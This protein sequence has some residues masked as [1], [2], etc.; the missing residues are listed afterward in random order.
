[1]QPVHSVIPEEGDETMR[2]AFTPVLLR[3]L[4]LLFVMLFDTHSDAAD[5][6][7]RK[8]VLIAGKKSHGPVGNGIHDYPWS[9]KLLKVMVDNSNVKD[10][11]RVEY[12]LEGWPEDERTFDDADTIMVISDG[13]DG[14]LYEEAPQFSTP[15]H[16]ACV[17]RQ[18]QRGCGFVTFHFSTFAPDKYADQILAWSGGYFD[19]ETDGKRQWYSAINTRDTE[20]LPASPEHPVLRGVKPFKMNEE[21]YYNLRFRPD[22]KA[23]KPIWVVPA[24]PGREP[25][26]RIVAWARERDDGGRGFGTT[27]GHFYANWQHDNF[28]R[29]ILNALA[30][31]AKVEVPP[32]GVAARF[33]THAEITAALA[34]VTGVE[35]AVVDDRP[36]KVLVLTG[37]QY[38]GH[39][40]AE[41]TPA[42]KESLARDA[43]F[44]VDVSEE[45]EVLATPKIFDYAAL[46]LNYCN[47]MKPGLSDASKA[48]FVKYLEQGGGL[49]IIHFANGAFHFSLPEAKES[50]WP[51]FRKICRRAWDHTPGKSGHDAYG[52]FIVEIAP[53]EHPVTAGMSAFQTI[54]ELYFR[55][56]GEE[57]I[58]VLATAKSQVTGQNEPM[59]FVYNYGKG[60]VFQTVLGHAAESLR[61]PGAAELVRRGTTWVAGRSIAALPPLEAASAPVVP[62][63]PASTK[64][65]VEGRF[66]QALNARA[67]GAF[68]PAKAAYRTPPLTVECWA[69]LDS[70]QSYNILVA[71]ELKTSATH[72]EL[73]SMT[74]SGQFTAYLPGMRPDH[75][76]SQV[77]ICDGKWH[78]LAM[79]F[80]PT[81][82]RL[83]VDGKQVA[84][85]GVQ[86]QNGK[87]IEGACAFGALVAKEIGC[88]GAIDEVRI[89]SG[90]RDI[91]GVPESPFEPDEQTRGLWHFDALDAGNRIPDAARE[92]SPAQLGSPLEPAGKPA[93]QKQ[94]QN[95]DHFGEDA[96]GF[97]WTEQDAVDNRWNQTDLGICMASTLFFPGDVV[98]KGLSIR[99]GEQGEATMCFDTGTLAYR[100]GWTGGFLDFNPARFGLISSPKIAGRLQFASRDHPGYAVSGSKS[101]G[102][103]RGH[104]LHDDRIVLVYDIGD[105]SVRETPWFER[106]DEESA[107][108]RTLEIGPHQNPFVLPILNID[109]TNF[110]TIQHG[111]P[112]AG[113]TRA[114]QATAVAVL[115]LSDL[116]PTVAGKSQIVVT[117]P[118]SRETQRFKLLIWCGWD[119]QL[120][121]FATLVQSSPVPESV[122]FLQQPGGP[123][124][125]KPIETQGTLGVSDA[126]YTLDTL[127]LPFD[128]PYKA[129]LFVSGHDFF[130]NGDI[131]ACTVHGDVWRISGADERLEKLTWKRFATGL[132][133]PLGLKV[134]NDQVYVLG[135]DQITRL[136]D[137]NG[138][139]EADEY[140]NFNNAYRTSPGGHDYVACLETD[141]AGNLYFVHANQGL[142]KVSPD[143]A[144]LDVVAT[145]F[146][147]PN[148]LG[149]GADGTI[150]VSPQEGNWTPASS[151]VQVKP[152][153]YYGFGG[154][155]VSDERPL[156]YDPPLCWIPRLRDNSSGG[157][158]WVTSDR[159]G[160]LAGQLLHFS[161]GKCRMLLTLREQVEGVM[162]GG[163]IDFPLN[164]DSGVM[165]GR[166]H[167]R[168]GQL[169]V[170]GLKGWVSSAVQDGCLQRVRYTGKPVDLPVAVRTRQNGLELEFTRP[171][172][173]RS[174]EDPDSYHVQR[175]N[176]LYTGNYGSAEYKVSK[177]SEEG[178]DEVDVLSATL[179][180]DRTVFLELDD[181]RPVMQMAIEYDLQTADGTALRDT[182]SYTV[183]A[184]GSARVDPA[185]LTRRPHPGQ[186]TAEQ[187]AA[188]QPGLR[189]T[190]QQDGR[191]DNR[192]ARLAALSVPAGAYPS[193]FLKPGP[194]SAVFT[195]YLERH[196]K[197]RVSIR[198][199]GHGEAELRINGSDV[200]RGSGDLAQT[201]AADVRLHKGFNRIELRYSS[202]VDGKAT[203]RLLWESPE[204][205]L[206]PIPST[207]LMTDGAAPELLAASRL[208]RGRELFATL[209]CVKC[210]A[211]PA[212]V[213]SSREAMPEL[214]R[215][216]PRLGDAG[217]VFHPEWVARWLL[218]PPSLRSP[219]TMP[220]LFNG[221][222]EADRQQAADLAAY[223]A[224]LAPAAASGSAPDEAT[225]SERVARG[226]ILYEDLGCI[227]CHRLTPPGESDPFSRTSLHFVAA[228]YRPAALAAFLRQPHRRYEFTR[229][230]DFQLNPT[231]AESLARYLESA[232]SMNRL[233]EVAIPVGSS[234][235]GQALF[236]T[237]RCANCHALDR[238]APGAAVV[239]AVPLPAQVAE[240]GCLS[241]GAV[242]GIP[243]FSLDAADRA[244]LAEF[245]ATDRRSLEQD[246]TS[247]ISE[248]LA[249]TLNCTACHT[250]DRQ[251]APRGSLLV[252]EG[253]RGL[254]P[255]VLPP[256]TWTGEKLHAGWTTRFLKG[257]IAE[258]PRPWLKARMPSFPAYARH[259]ADGLAAEHGIA[260]ET[261]PATIAASAHA[262]DLV[263]I[264]RQLTLKNAG[265]DC[266]QCH[267]VG[268]EP[269]SGDANTQIALGINFAHIRERLRHDY[270]RRFVFDPPRY[271][272]G[273]KMPKLVTG[274][275]TKV[276]Q[277]F[278]GDAERQF[279]A[280]WRYIQ[281][282]EAPSPVAN[283]KTPPQTP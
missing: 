114:G 93:P 134:I 146:R 208:R 128:N 149:V 103:W 279:E 87:S 90:I 101:P 105:V 172:D 180:S 8:V 104:S 157:Q 21:F 16:L 173:R 176:Y 160:P 31:T 62:D 185:L 262:A 4:T 85:Q 80:E 196:L 26:G 44:Q 73:F 126:A 121:E 76:N 181:L 136:H 248:R 110:E 265:L 241:A 186:L 15:E 268:R 190:L 32:E 29:L 259:L 77:D 263:E 107:F 140:E 35:R 133:Q 191:T 27:C 81:R 244:S 131:A 30:W 123:R 41:T 193:P 168:D 64:P 83:F 89:S 159:W 188:L 78:Y 217:A 234:E 210:H 276:T 222:H 238:S 59:A 158:T 254:P 273:S 7:T 269:A 137:R 38:P 6:K 75:V 225:D 138:D 142:L 255:E 170:S 183:N 264:G 187:Q 2:S 283:E 67:T 178:R 213:A 60:R 239:M 24:L 141:P 33:L 91:K 84:D 270:Y 106:H 207:A 271:D 240:R 49:T 179:L 65:L 232:T 161:F 166:F 116:R 228:K 223:L 5:S 147:N 153:G 247:E 86:F 1:M 167:P 53:V 272:I 261:Q 274:A 55:Q 281:T 132:F 19:W 118:P 235:R 72:W 151:I 130:S 43:R 14:D 70:K 184:V 36:I 88:A 56:Q 182:Q 113:V 253:S 203:L 216:A 156:G 282:I 74:G 57:P 267:A 260:P 230:P 145:G 220:K 96:V 18:M 201:A 47:W 94:A 28:R 46:V 135:R 12:H 171:L 63:K 258:R 275:R 194:F 154:P 221:E 61:T 163:T 143:G 102:R 218:D 11:L 192:I 82:V 9:V 3:L 164:F 148:G 209:N 120:A 237:A 98:R 236:R 278:D 174:A 125:T 25:D 51:E 250:R 109:G 162:Q 122:E 66:G 92:P 246:N 68:V 175:W 34:G 13:R 58:E 48:G 251:T 206:E 97:R 229:M 119:D 40:W 277:V 205:A 17:A 150:T 22:D 69:K 227:A 39:K 165:R 79:T 219:A 197:E 99:L 226:E 243:A 117:L 50:D 215:D 152:E 71:N 198:W 214:R 177:A 249:R 129:L 231:E 23:L 100:A 256:L 139:D 108:T 124:W 37:H 20:V 242:S 202:A 199:E 111:V 266:R 189:L 112:L 280:I 127:T 204:F 195:G 211:L 144:Q 200:L 10:Q 257:E 155:R 95:D 245:L 233:P 224:S 54:D 42:I 212:E 45:I 115:G 52:K 169:Y 252:E